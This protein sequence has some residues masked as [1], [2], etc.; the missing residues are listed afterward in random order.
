MATTF[1]T[2]PFYSDALRNAKFDFQRLR[3]FKALI[4]ERKNSTSKVWQ[5]I[6]RHGQYKDL[7]RA[8]GIWHC[9]ESER[10]FK[11]S[12]LQALECDLSTIQEVLRLDRIEF[13]KETQ[14]NISIDS[15]TFR[16]MPTIYSIKKLQKTMALADAIAETKRF[17]EQKHL[18]CWIE[19]TVGLYFIDPVG[20]VKQLIYEPRFEIKSDVLTVFG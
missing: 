18:K 8:F 14:R 9:L 1:F 6:M 10:Q 5:E 7:N 2:S 15:F 20:V 4:N 13:E 3:F 17:A 19:S 11:F 16:A 12:L